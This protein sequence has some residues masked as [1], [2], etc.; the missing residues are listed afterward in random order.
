MRTVL[1]GWVRH[2][3]P[4]DI[5][6]KIAG[7]AFS[8]EIGTNVTCARVEV[9]EWLVI[10]LVK[11]TAPHKAE[12][13]LLRC[14]LGILFGGK[15]PCA[16]AEYLVVMIFRELFRQNRCI[17]FDVDLVSAAAIFV[18]LLSFAL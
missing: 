14:I 17:C 18:I 16:I 2:V 15:T 13:Y 6:S 12:E 8:V 1:S 9:S 4:F 10:A 7:D 5:R 11:S 3:F